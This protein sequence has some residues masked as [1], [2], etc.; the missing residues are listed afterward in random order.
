MFRQSWK[1]CARQCWPGM[2]KQTCESL[3]IFVRLSSK[4][5]YFWRGF[6][7]NPENIFRK[8][9]LFLKAD[10]IQ[11]RLL[12]KSGALWRS[13]SKTLQN[14]K[15]KNLKT[16]FCNPTESHHCETRVNDTFSE[17]SLARLVMLKL[18]RAYWFDLGNETS[19]IGVNSLITF[20]VFMTL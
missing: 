3:T 10:Y 15:K 17:L 19:M 6:F 13:F 20:N 9:G 5:K 8:S 12:A 1:N 4:L 11:S 2:S 16:A 14:I 7:K 18:C